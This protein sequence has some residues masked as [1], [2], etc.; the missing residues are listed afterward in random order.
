MILY[1]TIKYYLLDVA[2]SI[3]LDRVFMNFRNKDN[4]ILL[5]YLYEG[6]FLSII[7]NKDLL[8][9]NCT[10]KRITKFKDS[11]Y[12]KDDECSLCYRVIFSYTS[13]C[14]KMEG[15]DIRDIGIDSFYDYEDKRYFDF[16]L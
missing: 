10:V 2:L 6:Q 1:K 9:R 4:Q 16:Y 3:F 11:E 8:F 7:E 14:Y 5:E 13:F 12:I 15:I